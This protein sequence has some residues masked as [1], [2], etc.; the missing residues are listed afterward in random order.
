MDCS[1]YMDRPL[2]FQPALPSG[3]GVGGDL[4]LCATSRVVTS[5]LV[6]M[7]TLIGTDATGHHDNLRRVE[8]SWRLAWQ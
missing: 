6:H 5:V 8:W 1:F 2:S 7:G 4:F 3:L